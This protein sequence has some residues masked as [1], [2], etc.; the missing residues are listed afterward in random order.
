MPSTRFSTPSLQEPAYLE[1]VLLEGGLREWRQIYEEI[2]DR[3]FGPVAR[4]LEQVLSSHHYYGVTPLW[5]AIL[6]RVQGR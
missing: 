2:A 1:E 4:S 6:Q 5:S 3:P